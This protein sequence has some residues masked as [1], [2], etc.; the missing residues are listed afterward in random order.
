[1]AA[2]IHATP[3]GDLIEHDTD[4]DDDSCVCGPTAVPLDIN[5]VTAWVYVHP[6]LDG[7]E[8]WED[9]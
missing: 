3:L 7:R 9:D 5:G 4:V 6:S 1:M 8:I 2:T